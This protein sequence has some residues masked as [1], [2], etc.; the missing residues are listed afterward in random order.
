M[1][2]EVYRFKSI[3]IFYDSRV[4]GSDLFITGFKGFGSVGYITTMHFV[5]KLSCSKAGFILPKYLPEE[6]TPDPRGGVAGAFT[7]Y[8]C[9]VNG[10]RKLTVLINNDVPVVHER[11]RFAEA[12]VRWL[13]ELNIGE[14]V[15]VGGFDSRFREGNEVLRWVASSY[16]SR[17]LSEP[18]MSHGLYVIGPLALLLM[19]AEIYSYPAVAILPYAEAARPDPRA[20]ATAINK[21]GELY[22]FSLPVDELLEKAK[23]IEEM[24]EALE[25]QQ[26]ESII[27]SGSERVYM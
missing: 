8:A 22:G 25:K 12:V 20:A 15:L 14:A 7:L 11:A 13:R 21:I 23:E 24:I 5:D 27:G 3:R 26:R 1:M 17:R 16:Y 2:L 10:D 18:L 6:V 19:F 9:S 4:R